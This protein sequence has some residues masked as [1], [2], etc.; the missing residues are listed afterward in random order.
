MKKKTLIVLL[1]C[2]LLFGVIAVVYAASGKRPYKAL[3]A[4]QL[5]YATVHLTPPDKTV[6]IADMEKLVE[7]LR[8]VVIYQKDNSYTEYDGQ[9]VIFTL[10]MADGTQTTIMAYN[11]FLVIDGVGYRTKYEPCQD[12]NQYANHLLDADD[13]VIILETPPILTVTSDETVCSTLLGTYS[14]RSRNWDGSSRS[15]DADSAHPLDCKDLLSLEFSLEETTDHTATLRF[16]EKPDTVSVR[17]WSDEHWSD[18]SAESE[19]VSVDGNVIALK[20]GGYIYEV[21][22]GWNVENGYGGTASYSFYLNRVSD[23]TESP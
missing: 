14:W 8:N 5:A 21:C 19:D 7:Y 11:P 12:L 16:W 15:I 17:C 4:S 3:D 9:G 1:T 23:S 20:P 22:A 10:F 2:V 13:A 18:P 6:E